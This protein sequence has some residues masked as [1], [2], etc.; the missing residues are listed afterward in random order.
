MDFQVI[1][2]NECLEENYKLWEAKRDTFYKYSLGT[3]LDIN[4]AQYILANDYAIKNNVNLQVIIFNDEPE[5]HDLEVICESSELGLCLLQIPEYIHATSVQYTDFKSSF[6]INDSVDMSFLDFSPTDGLSRHNY[7]IDIMGVV[8]E[9]WT[10]YNLPK[11]PGLQVAPA[12]EHFLEEE[13][14]IG[15]QGALIHSGLNV[16]GLLFKN[17]DSNYIAV[18]SITIIRF[19]SEYKAR[20]EFRGICDIIGDLKFVDGEFVAKTTIK[21]LNKESTKIKKGEIILGTDKYQIDPE[22]NIDDMRTGTKVP[23]RTYIALTYHESEMLNLIT[24]NNSGLRFERSIVMEPLQNYR[25]IPI[26]MNKKVIDI[27]GFMFLECSE[28]LLELYRL[29]GFDIDG[30][31]TKYWTR[32][33]YSVTSKRIYLLSN[34]DKTQQKEET[35]DIIESKNLPMIRKKKKYVVASLNA[36]DEYKVNNLNGIKLDDIKKL[37]LDIGRSKVDINF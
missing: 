33:P 15:I 36:I 6:L 9:R 22:G 28:E 13:F 24:T 1:I 29:E 21:P 3:V 4:Q 10:C 12:D 16:Y 32:N 19:I 23:F 5:I 11:M 7:P 14:K 25:T 31:W 27:N 17:Y 8:Y 35:L 26:N 34:I 2:M 20:K 18:P 37:T 30:S